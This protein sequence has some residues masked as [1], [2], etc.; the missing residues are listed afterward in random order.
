MKKLIV[1]ALMVAVRIALAETYVPVEFILSDGYA[2][3]DTGIPG[4]AKKIQQKVRYQLA[5]A[6]TATAA[7]IFGSYSEGIVSKSSCAV[8]VQ[9]GATDAEQGTF[10]GYTGGTSSGYYFRPAP[11]V[12]PFYDLYLHHGYAENYGSATAKAKDATTGY[13]W[14][15]LKDL[16][17][18]TLLVGNC[19]TAEGGLHT[20]PGSVPR[21]RWYSYEAIDHET[22]VSRICLTPAKCVESGEYGMLDSVN[23]GFYPSADAEHPFVGPEYVQWAGKDATYA[24]NEI[25]RVPAGTKVTVGSGD[26]AAINTTGGILVEDATSVFAFSNFT[27]AASLYVPFFGK[28]QVRQEYGAAGKT[29]SLLGDNRGFDGSISV[30]EAQASLENLHCLGTT[31]RVD[32]CVTSGEKIL[33]SKI[34]GSFSNEFHFGGSSAST[35][36]FVQ[37]GSNPFVIVGPTYLD[38]RASLHFHGNS[39]GIRFAG[40]LTNITSSADTK[41]YQ[42]Y[43]SSAVDF[44]GDTDYYFGHSFLMSRGT[45]G[46]GGKLHFDSRG[47]STGSNPQDHGQVGASNGAGVKFLSPYALDEDVILLMGW[48]ETTTLTPKGTI[49][50]NGFDQHVGRLITGVAPRAGT[51]DS[52]PQATDLVIT[53]ESE[54]KLVIRNTAVIGQPYYETSKGIPC[55][56]P[57]RVNGAASVEMD[58]DTSLAA[59]KI[60]FTCAGSDTTGGLY[61]RRGTIKLYDTATFTN[62]TELVASGEGLLEIDTS[63]VGGSNLCVALTNVTAGTVPLTIGEGCSI[64]A[65]TALVKSA[66]WLEPGTYTKDNLPLCIAGDGELVVK[67]YGGPKGLMLILR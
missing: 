7:A 2:Y 33:C 49:N 23:G 59:G 61:A 4:N 67:E 24:P 65:K 60:A 11:T 63:A 57:G 40:P 3:L 54:A 32:Y 46:L 50:L 6:P 17:F 18:S 51:A 27:A 26:V 39:G 16:E 37:D 30:I 56:W 10:V 43:I 38:F 41:F 66:K 14:G 12:G 58:T 44:M 13:A 53:S 55:T 47:Y 31:N 29:L 15:S 28:G 48:G 52:R 1:A 42:I 5:T 35:A 34:S 64:T 62:L 9:N 21:I 22:G 45:L 25:I 8:Y 20:T 36:R 19:H